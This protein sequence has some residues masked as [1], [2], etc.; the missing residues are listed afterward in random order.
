[1]KVLVL[2]DSLSDLDGVGRY[3]VR[4]LL[5]LERMKPDLQVHVLLARKHRPTSS[6][7][8]DRWRVEVALPPDYFF[9]MSPLRFWVSRVLATWRT[10]R[11]ARGADVVHA[12]KDF[13]HNLVALDGARLAGKPCLATAHGTYTIQPLLDPRH[14]RR[15]RRTYRRFDRLISVSGYTQ[16]R[17]LA[18]LDERELPPE[19]VVV[20]AQRRRRGSTT[21]SGATIGPRP[22][23]RP[24]LTPSASASSRSA[25][26]TTSPWP[27]GA[28]SRARTPVCTTC[29]SADVPGTRTSSESSPWRRKPGSRI[30]CTSSATSARTSWST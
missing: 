18:L 26:G 27:R 20:D 9:Y 29:W 22:L 2:T 21:G 15:A 13:P 30:V 7:V 28:R 19:R 12:I 5:A 11:A 17:L 14:A 16:R 1:M 24:A 8:P 6:A 10:W 4:L 3:T 23:A 25:R